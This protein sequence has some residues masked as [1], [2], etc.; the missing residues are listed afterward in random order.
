MMNLQT[1]NSHMPRLGMSCSQSDDGPYSLIYIKDVWMKVG[2]NGLKAD[3]GVCRGIAVPHI[4][5]WGAP[6]C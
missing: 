4:E 5:I 1:N 2:E 6:N 3:T